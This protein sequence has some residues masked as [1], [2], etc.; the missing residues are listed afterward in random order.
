MYEKCGFRWSSVNKVY[1]KKVNK[2]LVIFVN[3]IAS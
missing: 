1:K 2:E 3:Y